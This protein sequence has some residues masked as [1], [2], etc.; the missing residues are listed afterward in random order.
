M[1]IPRKKITEQKVDTSV[2]TNESS[3]NISGKKSFKDISI[4]TINILESRGIYL[5]APDHIKSIDNPE[6]EKD[7][8]KKL[9]N[10]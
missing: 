6:T 9:F 5:Y 3:V 4:E 10:K 8:I 7:M 1:K 2:N